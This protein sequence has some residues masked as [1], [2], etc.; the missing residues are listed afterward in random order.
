MNVLKIIIIKNPLICWLKHKIEVN[1]DQ[2]R[3]AAKLKCVRLFIKNNNNNKK[4]N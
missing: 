1:C 3:R 2:F 4:F